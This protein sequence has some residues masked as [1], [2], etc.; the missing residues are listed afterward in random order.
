MKKIYITSLFFLCFI[1]SILAQT[2][3]VDANLDGDASFPFTDINVFINNDTSAT[4][5]QLHDVYLLEAGGVYFFTAPALW[6]FDVTIAATGNVE[7]LG[8]PFVGRRNAAGGTSLGRIYTGFGSLTFDGLF[9]QL[10][11]EGPDAAQYETSPVRP[12]GNGKKYVFNNCIIEKSRQGTIRVEGEDAVVYVTNN[13]IRNYGDY[14]KFQGNGRVVD[15]RDN[16][17]DSVVI[18][19]NV[20][21]NILDRVF[22]G[23]R[24]TG[25]NYFEYTSNTL[26]NH[27]GRHGMIQLKNTK[28]TIIKDN[29]FMNPSI[30]G[31]APFLANEQGPAHLNSTNYLVSIDT[32]VAGASIDM[33]NNNIFWTEDVLEHYATFDSVSQPLILSPEVEGV[34]SN[35]ESAFFTEVLELNNVPD[36]QPLITYAREA[37]LFR[38]SVGIT[39]IMVEDISAA[40]S[41]FDNGYLFDFSTFDPCYSPESISVTASSEGGAIGVQF[42]CDYTT[43]TRNLTLNTSLGLKSAPNPA[44]DYTLLSYNL[45][46]AGDVE[47]SVHDMNGRLLTTLESGTKGEGTHTVNWNNLTAVP[48]GMYF[49]NLRTEEGRMFI[50]VIVE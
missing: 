6:P 1:G 42:L 12:E 48:T 19:N 14:E 49:V 4:G 22:I 35:P 9:L 37:V 31:T 16:F 47:L 46:K 39:D 27:V 13:I 43:S 15:L 28:E 50:K 2:I 38:D 45:S 24:Q 29:I 40:G 44:A 5:E 34:L 33:S 26:F 32:L 25:L 30:M 18:R 21:H 8:K 7:N 36:R 23:F 10:G 20:I 41:P 11:E 3:T 17:G